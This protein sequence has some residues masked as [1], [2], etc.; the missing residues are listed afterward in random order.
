[1][2]RNPKN[3]L[4]HPEYQKMAYD[5]NFDNYDHYTWNRIVTGNDGYSKFLQLYKLRRS[6]NSGSAG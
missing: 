1:M 5:L 3:E 6:R 2:D 4:T